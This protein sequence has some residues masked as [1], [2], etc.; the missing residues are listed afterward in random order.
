MNNERRRDRVRSFSNRLFLAIAGRR[1][2]A[3]SVVKHVGRTSGREYSNPVSAYPLGD[4]FVIP[5]LYG[6]GSQW[7]CNVL[8]T[9]RLTLRTKGRDYQL[10]RPSI[11]SQAEAIDAFPA[12]MRRHYRSADIHDFLWAHRTGE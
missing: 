9:G 1:W 10:S 3:Y 4:G 6:T 2:R 5:I 12:P 7:V 8:A 11:I